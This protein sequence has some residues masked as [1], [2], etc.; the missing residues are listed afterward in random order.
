[1]TREHSHT[2][3]TYS[4]HDVVEICKMLSASEKPLVCPL[5]GRELE[6]SEPIAGH[7]GLGKVWRV[8]CATCNRTAI[9]AEGC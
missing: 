7:R 9:I 1:M 6:V 3:V 4:P 8:D 2:P 5:C